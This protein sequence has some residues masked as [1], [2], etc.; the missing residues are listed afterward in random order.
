M[1]KPLIVL[2]GG[3]TLGSVMPLLAVAET[4]RSEADWLWLGS[5]HGVERAIIESAGIAYIGI[6]GGKWRRYGDW[7]N[8]RDLF[9][10]ALG[11]FQSWYH[12]AGRHPDL[13]ISAGSY[14]SLPSAWAAK[15]CGSRVLLHQLDARPGLANVL[16]APV[17]DKITVVWSKSLADYGRKAVKTGSLVR[18]FGHPDK[19]SACHH[20]Q[21]SPDRPII[22]VMGGG[23]GAADINSMLAEGWPDLDKCCQVIHITGRGKQAVDAES[24]DYHRYGLMEPPVL[25][26]AYAASDVVV[27]RAGMGSIL[28][29]AAWAKPAIII[30]LPHSHQIDNA[31]P[32]LSANAGVVVEQSALDGKLLVALIKDLVADE[33]KCKKLGT[34]LKRLLASD[35]G[36]VDEIKKLL[37]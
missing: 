37:V 26:M 9:L 12:L 6:S 1:K 34:N 8:L 29:L 33:T 15:L 4:L 18:D 19:L 5:H 2:S 3:G 7:R 24:S 10:I 28:D 16:M 23:T 14:I 17:A 20:L 30:P 13:F 27:S 22:L 35:N 31:T 36:L 21:L 11:F 25:A 32:I